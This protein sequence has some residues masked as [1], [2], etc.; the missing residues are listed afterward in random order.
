MINYKNVY[1]LPIAVSQNLFGRNDKKQRASVAEL[2]L[3]RNVQNTT[4]YSW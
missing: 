2:Q 1:H 3:N 4:F